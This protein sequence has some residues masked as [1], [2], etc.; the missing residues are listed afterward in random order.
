MLPLL[1]LGSLA[2]VSSREW[3]AVEGTSATTVV[4]V[5]AQTDKRAVSGAASN[6]VGAIVERYD[7]ENWG[8]EQAAGAGLLLDAAVGSTYT[9]AASM[10][11]ILI[12][13]DDGKSYATSDTLGGK[14]VSRLTLHIL[15]AVELL[16]MFL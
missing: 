2:G 9:V 14:I 3:V 8:K 10:L 1:A 16:L 11:P 6:G 13:N 12:S 4:G 7:G 15:L 5:G